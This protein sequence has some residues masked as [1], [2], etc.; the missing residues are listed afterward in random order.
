M[1]LLLI[2]IFVAVALFAVTALVVMA[3]VGNQSPAEARLVEIT[4]SPSERTEYGV[5][6][7]LSY[8]TRPLSP[9]R[10]LLQREGN[11]DLA[12]ELSL[13]GY[14]N[15]EDVDTYLNA[16]LLCP[17]LGVLLAT[18]VGGS[19]LLLFSIILAAAGFFAPN[20]F[21]IRATEKRKSQVSRSL[22]D[23]MDLLVICMD[24]G[25]GA[26][27]AMLRVAQ[28]LEPVSPALS[29]ELLII[30]REQRAG[31][32]RIEAWRSMADRVDLDTVH[33]FASMLAQS[34]RLG[35]PISQSL[36]LFADTLRTK[37]M[38]LAEEKA[39]KTPVKLLF[40][41]VFFIFPAIFVVILGPT[42]ITLSRALEGHAH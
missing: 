35:T 12:W 8:V 10:R 31:K 15:P 18:F 3:L 4:A 7:L 29:E 6:E 13:A 42:L 23:A 38:M 14:R 27:Q 30:S 9:I 37:R 2:A 24:A 34:E 17:A 32:P 25:L 20:F 28:E 33:Q 26:D 21:L 36:G 41:L 39:A 16:K 40:P 11:D 22:P 1:T 19:N 5:R